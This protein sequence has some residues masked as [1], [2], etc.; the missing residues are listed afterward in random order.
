MSLSIGTEEQCGFFVGEEEICQIYEGTIPVFGCE[1]APTVSNMVREYKG[2]VY[3]FVV[4]DFTNNFTDSNQDGY[5]KTK[6]TTLPDIGVIKYAG[7][8]IA[9]GYEFDLANVANL[10]Y[11]LEAGYTVSNGGYCVEGDQCYAKSR[12][13]ITFETSDDSLE[14]IYSNAATFAFSLSSE[15]TGPTV[16]DQSVDLTGMEYV[17]SPQ[18]FT[19]DYSDPEGHPHKDTF[20]LS[21]PAIGKLQFNETPVVN[22]Q[23]FTTTE[24]QSL[25]YV[26][27]NNYANYEGVMYKFDRSL[28]TIIQEYEALGYTLVTN[29]DG[30]LNFSNIDSNE[31]RTITGTKVISSITFKFSVSDSY[32]LKSDPT[33]MTI[34]PAGDIN[35]QSFN[36]QNPEL[37]DIN[38]DTDKGVVTPIT[39]E[40]I[41]AS[42]NDL[43]GDPWIEVK[44]DSISPDN[45]GE[46]RVNEIPI[47]VDIVVSRAD[48]VAGLFTHLGADAEDFKTDSISISV[49]DKV[50]GPWIS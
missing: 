19:K 50:D 25:K 31:F 13:K 39:V 32:G 23:S 8:A 33:I 29:S 9:A 11:E 42:Y 34:S 30:V 49:R 4:E 18:V 41:N 36:N 10:T 6:I 2:G 7:V 35:T 47:F 3:Q 37:Y 20:I 17:F 44:V 28:A 22:G 27:P 15:N 43:E 1:E 48:I 46:F 5:L 40:M 45:T 12:V 24:L 16:S 26:L 38:I 14:A 21:Q